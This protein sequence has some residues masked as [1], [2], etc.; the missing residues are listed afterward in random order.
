MRIGI[1]T[2]H[3]WSNFGGIL[4]N[5]ALQTV[6]QRMGHEV[7]TLQPRPKYHRWYVMPF[8][9]LLRIC[10]NMYSPVKIAIKA[11]EEEAKLRDIQCQYTSKFVQRY[12]HT[13]QIDSYSNLKSQDFDALVVGS[14]QVWRRSLNRLLSF[15]VC[16]FFL[17]FAQSWSPIKRVAYAASFGHDSWGY[18]PKETRQIKRLAALFDGI[19]VREDAGV[20]LCKQYMGVNAEHVLDPTMLL[21]KQD[22]ERLIHEL[23]PSPSKGDLFAYI[24]DASAMKT[25]LV[26]RVAAD[27]NLSPFEVQNPNL[28]N[29]RVS[30]EERIQRPVEEWLRAFYDA[31][32]VV[33]DSFHGCVFSIIFG[34]PFIAIGNRSRGLSR[35]NS[36]LKMF[37]LED[38][39]LGGMEDYEEDRDYSIPASTYDALEEWRILSMRFLDNHLNR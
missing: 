14:D 16:D 35:F 34:K 9:Y 30:Y 27:R 10:R 5:Y 21:S 38:H 32:M 25:D 18:S 31:K 29:R 11:E 13:K 19:S 26:Q 12:I 24:L 20:G 39:L 4:Q 2:L 23:K 15:Q 17:Q 6:L 33:T 22:Y 1:V 28:T 3:L 36:L 8:I 37:H 7:I